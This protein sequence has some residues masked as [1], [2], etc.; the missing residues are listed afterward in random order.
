MQV[1]FG[2]GNVFLEGACRVKSSAGFQMKRSIVISGNFNCQG[3]IAIWC[4]AD[5][6]CEEEVWTFQL[7]GASAGFLHSCVVRVS[8]GFVA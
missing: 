2:F 1:R 4:S 5:V 3:E 7:P 8:K 6:A